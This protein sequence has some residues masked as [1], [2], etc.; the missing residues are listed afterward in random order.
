MVCK[1]TLHSA[2]IIAL[3][4]LGMLALA[5]LAQATPQTPA[6]SAHGHSMMGNK[7][8]AHCM[9][10]TPAMHG[11]SMHDMSRHSDMTDATGAHGMA[12]G[13]SMRH[14]PDMDCMTGHSRMH[15]MAKPAG[16]DKHSGMHGGMGNKDVMGSGSAQH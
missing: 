14:A 1:R 7:A 11:T 9:S 15:G 5:G 4:A 6:I 12:Q 2:P 13:S 10:N 16:M 3:A 8:G